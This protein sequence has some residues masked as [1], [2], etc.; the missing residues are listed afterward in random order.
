[1]IELCTY[2]LGEWKTVLLDGKTDPVKREVVL[3]EM[4]ADMYADQNGTCAY[5]SKALQQTAFHCDHIIP[6]KHGGP[7]CRSNLQLLC[8]PCHKVKS[9]TEHKLSL[10]RIY[11]SDSVIV[12]TST[13]FPHARPADFPGLRAGTYSL[14][15][16]THTPPRPAEYE[17]LAI[18]RRMRGANTRA[19]IPY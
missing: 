9:S 4:K 17:K 19:N 7:T 13:G 11:P 12:K 15:L 1:M 18:V 2:S 5:C 16:D 8:R 3:P 10:P 14:D 6:V